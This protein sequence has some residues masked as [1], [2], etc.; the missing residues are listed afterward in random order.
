MRASVLSKGQTLEWVEGHTGD[1]HN[2]VSNKYAK[3][4][5]V[6][7]PPP[8][9]IKNTPWD[10]IRHRER[11]PPPNKVWTQSLFPS[12]THAGFHPLSWRP[13]RRK[14]L[15]WHKWLFRDSIPSWLRPLRHILVRLPRKARMPALPLPTQSKRARHPRFLLQNTPP[16]KRLVVNVECRASGVGVAAKCP[17]QPPS[18]SRPPSYTKVPVPFPQGEAWRAPCYA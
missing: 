4:R 2:V 3:I 9:A 8:P 11:I 16:S 12:H 18:H 15:A 5:T 17:S 6:L 7:P 1:T 14:R 13:L 10:V